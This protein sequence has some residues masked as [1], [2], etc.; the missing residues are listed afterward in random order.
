MA[1]EDE[2]Y[3]DFGG[4]MTLLVGLIVAAA[5]GVWMLSCAN[6]D[7]KT[8]RAYFAT[9]KD[10]AAREQSLMRCIAESLANQGAG[11]ATAPIP[12]CKDVLAKPAPEP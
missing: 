7:L 5:L 8:D 2:E 4:Q 1:L 12:D 10:E 9:M 3:N 11:S 6:N